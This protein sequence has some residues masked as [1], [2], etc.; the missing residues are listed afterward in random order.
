M[1]GRLRSGV[2]ALVLCHATKKGVIRRTKPCFVSEELKAGRST[3]SSY[4]RCVA[5]T[6]LMIVWG[7]RNPGQRCASRWAIVGCPVGASR[8]AVIDLAVSDCQR[9]VASS[10]GAAEG[11]PSKRDEALSM[12]HGGEI[13]LRR[14]GASG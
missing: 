13:Q 9:G 4:A 6:G 3:A 8:K 11:G 12:R 2:I 14:G 1:P 10:A 7:T 5:L